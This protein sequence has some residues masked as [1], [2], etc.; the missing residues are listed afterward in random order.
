[1]KK[2]AQVETDTY[3]EE[4]GHGSQFDSLPSFTYLMCY[5]SGGT[6]NAA[7]EESLS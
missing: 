1:M 5:L 2:Y 7:E 6:I 4:S 3:V